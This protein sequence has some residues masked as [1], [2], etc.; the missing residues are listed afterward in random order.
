[1]SST[2]TF[3]DDV[4]ISYC[5]LDNEL[6]DEQ[7]KG[8]V[9]NFHKQFEAV[10]TEVRGQRSTVWR[11]SRL[12][13]NVDFT[14]VLAERIQKTAALISIISPGY[15]Q[16]DW[17]MAELREFCRLADQTG[18]LL[19]GGGLRVFKVLKTYI[20]FEQHPSEFRKQPGYEFYKKDKMTGTPVKFRQEPEG[21]NCDPQYWLRLDVLARE[22]IKVLDIIKPLSRT[23][24]VAS[25]LS[26]AEVMTTPSAA[27]A[28]IA[29][30]SSPSK[31]TIYLAQTIWDL[32]DERDQIK[33]ELEDRGYA[34]LPDRELSPYI[35]PNYEDAVRECVGRAKLSVHLIGDKYGLIP[36]GAS[37][38]IIHMQNEIAA[39]RSRNEAFSRLLWLPVGLKPHEP[40]Q[41]QF[42][43]Q[44]KTNSEMQQG[45]ELLQTPLEELKTI[46]QK[47]LSS[48]GKKPEAPPGKSAPKIYLI[49]D[50]RD[51]EDV[52]PLIDYLD[53]KKY[54]V[55]LPI[56]D[57]GA[58]E[59]QAFEIHNNNLK[60]C[61]AVLIYYGN[62]QQLWFEY[63]WRELKKLVGLNRKNPLTMEAIYVAPPK[64]LHKQLFKNPAAAVIKEFGNFAPSTALDDFLA[65]VQA[66][67]KGSDDAGN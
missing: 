40:Q 9:D 32:N 33:R 30:G 16:S 38:S 13:G 10:L 36:E 18:G 67:E 1:M 19:T 21:P 25:G 55:L 64:T 31:G 43:E 47:R 23:T 35:L 28:S 5:H 46:I 52:A 14:D 44:L 26:Q 50:R 8:W 45:A 48:N 61:D 59:T 63:K 27:A 60:E 6:L 12:P 39:E 20:P 42:I 54:E 17:C 37:H 4:F 7:G 34:T 53:S 22:V 58:D 24:S 15:L 41:E 51:G 62:A 11:D 3:L 29:S 49:C 2:Q 66:V 56:L 65:R 57:E